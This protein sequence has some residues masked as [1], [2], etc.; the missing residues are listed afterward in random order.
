MATVEHA[1]SVNVP[2]TIA[3]DQWTQFEDFPRFMDGVESVT[4]IDDTHVHWV[5]RIG[6]RRKEWDAEIHEQVPDR[7][8]AWRSLSG[9]RNAGVVT[10]EPDGDQVTR[11]TLHMDVEPD[12]VV[13]EAG[14][15]AGFLDRQ[16]AGDLERF[17]DFIESRGE[18][19]GGW[20]GEVE[21]G[22]VRRDEVSRTR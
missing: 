5:A 14:T 22:Q 11:V 8:V 15:A 19:T 16:V 9:A 2:V 7:R 13:E 21:Q 3:Y 12:G 20:R 1:I 4:Q 6:G 17:K 18:E 10:F